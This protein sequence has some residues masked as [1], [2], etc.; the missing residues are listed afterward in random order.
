MEPSL[1]TGPGFERF[2]RDLLQPVLALGL[3]AA[4]PLGLALVFPVFTRAELGGVLRAGLALGLSLPMIWTSTATVGAMAPGN[5]VPLALLALKEILVGT[6]LG[7]L[8]GLPFWAIQSVG[9]LMDTQRGVGSEMAG[10]DPTTRSQ[11]SVMSLFLGLAAAA[12]FVAADGLQTVAGTL[13][14]SYA[15]WP[16]ASFAPRFTFDTALAAVGGLDHILRFAL[17]VGG[18]VV[19]LLLLIDLSVMLIGR[20]APQLN[21]N[22]LA[23]TIKN[24]V[25]IVFIALYATYLV[26]YMR[27][28]LASTIGLAE[29]LRAFVGP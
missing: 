9:E 4:R 25:F 11:G 10:I 27:A 26:D 7:F 15:V 8:L 28:E 6:L 1:L 12:L 17:L 14:D 19:A 16:Q 18:P 3:A 29:R 22:D 2:L 13:Y 5:P 23:P 24:V 20:S 21:A